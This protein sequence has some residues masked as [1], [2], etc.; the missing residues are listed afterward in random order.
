MFNFAYGPIPDIVLEPGFLER[1]RKAFPTEEG[2]LASIPGGP[3][4][5]QLPV[6]ETPGILEPVNPPSVIGGRPPLPGDPGYDPTLPPGYME[7]SL[8]E[9]QESIEAGIAA[10]LPA[11][12]PT[13]GSDAFKKMMQSS[14]NM[15]KTEAEMKA[16]QFIPQA[17]VAEEDPAPTSEAVTTTESTPFEAMGISSLGQDALKQMIF[18]RANPSVRQQRNYTSYIG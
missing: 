9:D 15:E 2:Q 3:G 8:F 6:I 11:Y 18:E 17:Y 7:P 4:A 13:P 14:P 5:E 16:K 12:M 1:L 10:L